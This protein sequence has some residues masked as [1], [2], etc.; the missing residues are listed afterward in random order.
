LPII[1]TIGNAYTKLEL[2]TFSVLELQSQTVTGQ[3]TTLNG[4]SCGTVDSRLY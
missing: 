3:K 4:A 1:C 2:R